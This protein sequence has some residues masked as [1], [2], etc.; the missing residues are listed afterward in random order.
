MIT[1]RTLWLAIACIALA[2]V[3]ARTALRPTA[4][5]PNYKAFAFPNTVPLGHWQPVFTSTPNSVEDRLLSKDRLFEDRLFEDLLPTDL[6]SSATFSGNIAAHRQ[7]QYQKSSQQSADQYLAVDIRYLVNTNGNLKG[8][9][10]EE[11]KPSLMSK[12]QI[13]QQTSTQKG[14]S[15]ISH[16]GFAY[17]NTCQN[18]RGAATLSTEQF[19]RNRLIYDLRPSRLLPWLQG[20]DTLPDQR[21]LWT[22]ITVP[23][24]NYDSEADAYKAIETAWV[25]WS[26]WWQPNFPAN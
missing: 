6:S 25:E 14:Y 18:S 21:C 7:Y 1:F 23:L 8:L 12:Q 11:I 3:T 26:H 22:Q 5:Q 16:E 9:I 20:K 15:L 10:A 24:A 4:Q 2:T 17:L 19:S 13:E